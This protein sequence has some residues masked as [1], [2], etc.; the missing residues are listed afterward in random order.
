[1]R[2]FLVGPHPFPLYYQPTTL[3][4]ITVTLLYICTYFITYTGKKMSYEIAN[5]LIKF[6]ENGI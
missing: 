6:G 5:V 2:Y 3:H 4:L 1:M